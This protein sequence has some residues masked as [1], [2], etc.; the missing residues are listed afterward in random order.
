M[1][2][3][4]T[5]DALLACVTGL[6]AKHVYCKLLAENDN[7]KQQIYLGKNFDVLKLLKFGPVQ[8]FPGGKRPNFKANV[9]M[10][11]IDGTGQAEPATGAQL[12]LYP[13][14]PEVRL[15]GFLRGCKLAPSH[16]LQPIPKE[17]RK[18]NQGRDGRVM[19]FAVTETDVYTYLAAADTA[20][21]REIQAVGLP[22]GLPEWGT[23]QE[24]V[25]AKSPDLREVLLAK[26]SEFCNSGWHK[27]QRLN[28]HGVLQPYVAQNGG[29]YT[30][31]A[32]FGIIPNGKS[33]PDFMGWELKA[34]SSSRITLMT[35]EPDGGY[36]G[37]NGVEAFLRRY[38]RQLEDDVIYFTGSH[39]SGVPS[40]SSG[41]TLSISGF[42]AIANKVTDVDGGIQLRAPD[43]TLSAEWSFAGLIEHWGRKHAA[44]AYIPYQKSKT[45]PPEYQYDSP[46]LLGEGTQFTLFLSALAAGYVVYDPAPK[47]MNASGIRPK[48]KARSQFRM[49][50]KDLHHLYLRF[51]EIKL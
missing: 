16:L 13:D 26:L 8:T 25:S 46:I 2:E 51:S 1:K 18:F 49:K 23:L 34:Y 6:G 41:H 3:F 45:I 24:V 27:S 4:Q 48:T 20:V 47:L 11:W 30:L 32:L 28:K 43:G 42:D 50:V 15:S 39:K 29:G 44:A 36:Y 38:G 9:P 14:Y 5:L 21:A 33:A 37:N 31:E 19:F 7:T 40:A 10:S 12:I 22:E 35:P 17:F